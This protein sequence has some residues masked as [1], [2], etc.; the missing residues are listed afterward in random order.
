MTIGC[1]P[2][3]QTNFPV[4]Y[5]SVRELLKSKIS[6]CQA[7]IHIVGLRYGEEPRNSTLAKNSNLSRRSYTQ[8]EYDI[9]I[10]L[11]KKVFVFICPEDF[12]FDACEEKEDSE[13]QA[14][15]FLHRKELLQGETLRYSVESPAEI[16]EK[17]KE[18]QVRVDELQ[19]SIEKQEKQQQ[20]IL[21]RVFLGIVVT[22]ALIVGISI[23]LTQEISER[24]ALAESRRKELLESSW[25]GLRNQIFN[26][27]NDAWTN[28]ERASFGSA[29]KLG[30]SLTTRAISLQTSIDNVLQ[31][32]SLE[33]QNEEQISIRLEEVK[34]IVAAISS[35]GSSLVNISSRFEAAAHQ[36]TSGDIDSFVYESERE[37][38]NL[39]L[40]NSLGEI[41]VHASLLECEAAGIDLALNADHFSDKHLEVAERRNLV[42][43]MFLNAERFEDA[44][45]HFQASLEIF[46]VYSQAEEKMLRTMMNLGAALIESG[47][48]LEA[49]KLLDRVIA[50]LEQTADPDSLVLGRTEYHI[51]ACEFRRGNYDEA[52][53]WVQQSITTYRNLRL[54]SEVGQLRITQ[55]DSLL[56]QIELIQSNK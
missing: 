53:K 9:A 51:G 1:H 5:R 23:F 47:Q 54:D 48:L 16:R 12:P 25:S 17:V 21:K 38:L 10:E 6:E 43:A 8:I 20:S 35:E 14:L 19:G 13:K 27:A 33:V 4:D 49:R 46:S 15:Q 11:G 52:S 26:Y 42:G 7:L 44:A 3:E 41:S 36:R 28:S 37:R 40:R 56:R 22:I 24:Q 45:M 2:I 31:N 50:G 29:P 32:M 39:S 34:T 18:I 55:S 30:I